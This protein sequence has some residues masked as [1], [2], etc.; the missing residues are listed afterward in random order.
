M[1]KSGRGR[2]RIASRHCRRTPYPLPSYN[3]EEF[4]GLYAT[5]C[6]N[7]SEKRDWED[8]TC[9]VCMECPHNAVLLLCSSHDKGC[10]PYMCGTSDRHS[11][12]LDQYRKAYTKIT[13]N[14]VG[15]PFLGPEES[16]ISTASLSSWSAAEKG[17]IP[18]LACPLCRG[19]VKGWT[20]VDVARDFL[21]SKKR[22]CMQEN[23]S[24]LGN[25]KELRK[26][27]R[28]VHPDPAMRPREA[29][30]AVVQEWR[31][32]E[33]EREHG[34]VMSVIRSSMPGAMVFGDFVIDGDDFASDSDEDEGEEG[35]TF[36]AN[37]TGRNGGPLAFDSGLLNMLLLLHAFESAGANQRGR[38]PRVEQTLP[39]GGGGGGRSVLGIQRSSSAVDGSGFSDQDSSEDERNG[40]D[41]QNRVNNEAVYARPPGRRRRHR[42]G[43]DN[44]GRRNI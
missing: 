9:S 37:A 4:E 29:D 8:V 39:G 10:R 12:C 7:M 11:N 2:R 13:P 36:H 24:F 41:I 16:L 43:Q 35:V 17:D 22:S 19:Q 26:H 15:L 28:D 5:N 27:V 40:G 14:C 1:A 21:N 38:S 18:E 3:Q 34:D 20:V 31:R 23:C 30:P 44:N 33:N 25:Y 42:R 6:S 32:I